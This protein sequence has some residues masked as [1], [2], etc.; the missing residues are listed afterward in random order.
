M[1]KKRSGVGSAH[2]RAEHLITCY[3]KTQHIVLKRGE[4][5]I[6]IRIRKREIDNKGDELKG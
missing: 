4:T 3:S 1:P 6:W 5:A 2:N